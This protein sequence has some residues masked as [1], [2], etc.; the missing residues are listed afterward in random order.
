MVDI[1]QCKEKRINTSYRLVRDINKLLEKNWEV[2]VAIHTGKEI[3]ML[4]Q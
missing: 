1:I 3:V 4:I 2:K